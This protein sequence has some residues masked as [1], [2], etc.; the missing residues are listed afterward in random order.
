MVNVMAIPGQDL[1]DHARLLAPLLAEHAAEAERLR[2][3]HDAVI[4]ALEQAGIFE[5][6]VPRRFGG[7]ELDLDTFLEVGLALAEGDASM[8][9][10]TTFYIEHNWMFSQFPEP[11]QKE[12]FE[13][14]TYVLAPGSVAP[15]GVAQPEPGGFRLDGRWQFA[16]GVVHGSWVIAGARVEQ[17]DGTLDL[18]FLALPRED[19]EVE[20]TWHVDGM[21]G[22][23]SHD[24]VIR[25]QFVPEERSVSLIE[26]SEGS[27]PGSRIHDGPLYHTP[28]VP[29]LALAA[30]M[31]AIGQARAAV[32]RFRER[33]D[34]RTLYGTHS[35]QAEKPAAQMR[36]ARADIEARQAET[37]LRG[38]IADVMARRNDATPE[39][40][41]RWVSSIAFAVDQSRRVVARVA[42]ASGAH[43][44]FLDDPLQRS[45]RDLDVLA[46]HMIFDLDARLE[47]YGRTMLGKD[48]AGPL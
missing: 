10:V 12:L 17:P 24:I 44:H 40:R 14:R 22:T 34:E 29:I 21:C 23:G 11:F 9:W 25:D 7:R 48:P 31:P 2:Q 27:A 28:M 26:M 33:M 30:A 5:L 39:D 38:V 32:N 15:S 19:V 46:T 43:A 18:R 35:K 8:S 6:M 3:P 45:K 13:G 1:V 42:E 47:T 4:E 16:T 41:G 36:L 37:L 20:D